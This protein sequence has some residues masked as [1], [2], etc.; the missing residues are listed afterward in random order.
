ASTLLEVHY[1]TKEDSRA[2]ALQPHRFFLP[3]LEDIYNREISPVKVTPELAGGNW[4]RGKELFFG[5][6]ICATCHSIGGK[7][8]SLG[9]DLSN[10]VF[11]DYKSVLRDIQDP[12]ASINPD[13]VAH[14]VTLKDNRQLIG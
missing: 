1:T 4:S 9:P 6:A 14:T 2:R 3:W 12:S 5:Q 10:L 8:K 11:R 7:G 13:Y